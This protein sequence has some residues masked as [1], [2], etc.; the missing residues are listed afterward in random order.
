VDSV[1]L[2]QSF[3]QALSRLGIAV[4][5]NDL[6][7]HLTIL[8][9]GPPEPVLLTSDRDDDLVKMPDVTRARHFTPEPTGVIT[10]ELHPQWGTVS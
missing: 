7:K 3:Q 1:L 6:I 4:R 8:I 9:D 5:L 10:P 2:Q